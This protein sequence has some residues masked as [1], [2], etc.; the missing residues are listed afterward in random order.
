MISDNNI[1]YLND[2]TNVKFIRLSLSGDFIKDVT[3]P[4]GFRPINIIGNDQY[5]VTMN[6]HSQ[7]ALFYI[8]KDKNNYNPIK[9]PNRE[10]NEEFSNLFRKEGRSTILGNYLIHLTKYYPNLYI[11]DLE[12]KEL[13]KKIQFDE[14]EIKEGSTTTRPDGA[15]LMAPPARVDIL[16]K[17]VATVPAFPNRIFILAEGKSDTRDYDL[18]KLYEFDI[19]KEAFVATHELGVKAKEITVNDKYL[20]VYSEEENQIFQYEIVASE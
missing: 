2:Y 7:K 15:K 19:E 9:L 4:S 5:R 16:S 14:S 11:Y 20:F 8:W 6:P 12:K 17:D 13:I 3:P 10:F 18:D 1:I